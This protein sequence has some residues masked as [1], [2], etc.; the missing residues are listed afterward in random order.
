M[1]LHVEWTGPRGTFAGDSWGPVFAPGHL[2]VCVMDSHL[3]RFGKAALDP[4]SIDRIIDEN[5]PNGQV[6]VIFLSGRGEELYSG[7][8]AEALR[9]FVASMRDAASTP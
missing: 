4:R 6:K 2:G 7:D 1:V 9:K 5:P 3:V 8:D